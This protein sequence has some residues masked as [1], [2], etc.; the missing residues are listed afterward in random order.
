MPPF[1]PR[2][3]FSAFSSLMKQ[4]KLHM[5]VL[6]SIADR[7]ANAQSVHVELHTPETLHDFDMQS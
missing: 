7:D 1:T 6:G 3:S 2:A 5:D 4:A